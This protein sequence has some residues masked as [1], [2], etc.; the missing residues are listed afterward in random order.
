MKVK[1]DE[2][3][4]GD[5]FVEY[6]E[7]EILIYQKITNTPNYNAV[8]LNK[9]LLCNLYISRDRYYNKEDIEFKIYDSRR[10]N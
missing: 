2:M 4:Q 10:I 1:W 3:K 9:G 6:I 8:L 5:F 7:D